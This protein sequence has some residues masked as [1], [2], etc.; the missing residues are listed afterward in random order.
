MNIPSIILGF[1]ISTLFG[2]VFHLLRGGNLGR[3]ILYIILAWIGFW[4]GHLIGDRIDW[5]FGKLGQLHLG[6]AGIG[7]IFTLLIGYWLSLVEKTR[8]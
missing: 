7:T 8:T 1:A 5:N 4:S 2:A 3:L 6:M